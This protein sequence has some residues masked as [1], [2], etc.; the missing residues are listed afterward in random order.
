M[1]NQSQ[2][3]FHGIYA[4][5]TTPFTPTGEIVFRSLV[6]NIE[7]YLDSDLAGFLV[8]GSTGEAAHLEAEERIAVL[9]CVLESAN[10]RP[11]MAGRRPCSPAAR[12]TR[13]TAAP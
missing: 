12:H 11:V 2:P 9:D 13:P 1:D 3:R 6:S 7:K 10:G 8:A 5:V 4:P